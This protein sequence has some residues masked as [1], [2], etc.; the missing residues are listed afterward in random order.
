[1][2]DLN[3]RELSE[4][5]SCSSYS[6]EECTIAS[7]HRISSTCHYIYLKPRSKVLAVRCWEPSKSS[8]PPQARRPGLKVKACQ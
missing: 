2:H 5:G 8:L 1:M 6:V 4:V 7:A 3:D